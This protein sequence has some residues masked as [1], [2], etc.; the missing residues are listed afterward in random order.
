MNDKKDIASRE[1][2]VSLVNSFYDKVKPNPTLGYIFSDVAKLNW[3]A[4]LPVM[5]NFWASMLLGENTYTGNPMHKHIVLSKLTPLTDKEF[6]EWLRL[7]HE[8]VDDL[9]AGVTADEAK[10]R[11]ANIARMMQLKIH[12][13]A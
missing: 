1:D 12:S 13:Q 5:Y 2:I 10:T 7:F 9:F 8:T 6:S 11:A 3:N 4:H